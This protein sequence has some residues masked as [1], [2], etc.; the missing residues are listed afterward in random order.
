MEAASEGA[1]FAHL[2]IQLDPSG[3]VMG[4]PAEKS[5]KRVGS[6]LEPKWLL[7]VKMGG[8]ARDELEIHDAS[9]VAR[10]S[11]LLD[12]NIRGR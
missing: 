9:Q 12:M 10:G 11:T 1:F 7:K 2:G 5:K 6:L 3:E 8:H 4:K